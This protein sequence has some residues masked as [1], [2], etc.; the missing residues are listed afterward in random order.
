[1]FA[2][3]VRSF[4]VITEIPELATL[5]MEKVF[6]AKVHDRFQDDGSAELGKVQKARNRGLDH[7]AGAIKTRSLSENTACRSFVNRIT[8]R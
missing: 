3:P 2:F 8:Y 5:A 7:S 1:M 6:Q 4:F